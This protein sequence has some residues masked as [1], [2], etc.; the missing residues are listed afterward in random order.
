[1]KKVLL[2]IM[3]C[4]P[5]VLTAQNG[6]TVSNLAVDAGTV[7]FNVSWKDTGMQPVWSDTVWVWVDY[8]KN[9]VMERLPL[10]AG[11]TLTATSALGVGEVIEVPGNN[12]GVWVV[13][14]ARDASAFSATVQLV[15]TITNIG[16]ACAYASNYP[17]VGKYTST[18]NITFTGTPGY[19]LVFT[20]GATTHTESSPYTVPDGFMVQSFTDKTGAPGK[21]GC[22]PMS[23]SIDFSVPPNVPKGLAT[24]FEVLQQNLLIPNASAITYTWSA[25]NFN[26]SSGTGIIYAPTAPA[27]T[28][29]YPVTLTARSTGYCDLETS[30]TVTVIECNPSLTYTLTAS[31]SGFCAGDAGVTFALS[32]T[33]YGRSYELYRDGATIAAMLT[34]T[35]SAQTFTTPINV[36]GTYTAKV[37][38]SGG[39]CEATMS[40]S[41]ILSRNSLPTQPTIAKPNDVCLNSGDIVFTATD[42]SGSLTWVSNGGGAISGNSVT[43]AS[44]AA[45]GTKTVKARSA[46]TYTNAPTCYSTEVTQSATVTAVPA[47]PTGTNGVRCGSGT[48]TISATLS[49][50]V[51]D[52]YVAS[53]GGTS[54]TTGAS[55]TPNVASS[56]TYYAE[57]RIVATN[58]VS[59]SRTAVTATMNTVPTINTHPASVATCSGSTVQLTVA[60]SS[61]TGYQWMKNGSNVTDGSGGTT[62]SYRTGALSGNATYTVVESNAACTVTSNA[63]YITATGTVPNSTVNFTTF[64]PCP[65]A[66]IGTVWYLTDTRE[67][68][69]SPSNT[70]TYKVKKMADGRIW[71]VQDLKF[72]NGCN[73]TAFSG[74]NVKDQ[75]GKV[76]SLTDKT[77]YG[78]CRNSTQSGAGY[79]YDW[80]A[81]VNKSGAYYGGSYRGCKGT[82]TGTSGTAPGVCQGI[83]PVGWHVP[84][85]GTDGEFS[86]ASIKFSSYYGCNGA[87]CWNPSSQFESVNGGYARDNQLGWVGSYFFYWSS[88]GYSS[89]YAWYF[90][91]WEGSWYGITWFWMTDGYPVRCIRNYLG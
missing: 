8:N 51:I 81:A 14:N 84:T 70:Q 4:I 61:A 45:T 32:G 72:G 56:T 67:S 35:G 66:A 31:A 36:S 46:Q 83:C 15:T 54:L 71:M 63:A 21:L 33:Q 38:A 75:T 44:G 43:F 62:A 91:Y 88:T 55:Y 90:G 19:D 87:G 17:P 40:G 86:D 39:D 82:V 77:Y 49:D 58:C 11:A 22:I 37:L 26:P 79:L 30:K 52:W 60:A 80:A 28:G 47:A 12:Q 65:N 6:V 5:A 53:S 73:K 74:S 3:M 42:Y 10:S 69:V 25:V 50:V 24:S 1:M 89:E 23:G 16:G 13:G 57:A 29:T 9:G 18:T 76:T 68:G 48:V 41:L 85:G 59:A 7:T 2:L 64:D 27:T 78:D 34:G 20:G